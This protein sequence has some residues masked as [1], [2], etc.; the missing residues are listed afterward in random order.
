VDGWPYETDPP[1]SDLYAGADNASMQRFTIARHGWKS[2]STAPHK[3]PAGATLVGKIN[4]GSVDGHAEAVKLENLWT[5][6]WHK[7]WVTPAKRPPVG[8]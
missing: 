8:N 6:Y 5:L 2:P 3:I 4:I 7:G 1:A